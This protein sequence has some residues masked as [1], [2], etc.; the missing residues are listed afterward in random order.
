MPAQAAKKALADIVDYLGIAEHNKTNAQLLTYIERAY[1]NVVAPST[2]TNKQMVGAEPP[3]ISPC[4]KCAEFCK[5]S[6]VCKL[7]GGRYA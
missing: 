6:P 2:S 1:A 5:G 7:G 3:Q 4:V